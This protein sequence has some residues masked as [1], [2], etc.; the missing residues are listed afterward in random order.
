MEVSTK[1]SASISTC[2][3]PCWVI[4]LKGMFAS[5]RTSL[6]ILIVGLV[7]NRLRVSQGECEGAWERM[8][9]KTG[10]HFEQRGSCLKLALEI[11]E[12]DSR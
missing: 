3:L 5:S 8:R 2:R 12:F 6:T 11:A 1:V 7:L 9:G 4:D 10:G